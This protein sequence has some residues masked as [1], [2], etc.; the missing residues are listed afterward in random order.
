MPSFEEIV[1]AAKAARAHDFILSFPE[2]YN[3]R[4]GERG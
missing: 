3:T 2:G 1:A 4:V